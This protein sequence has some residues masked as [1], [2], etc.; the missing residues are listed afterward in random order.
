MIFEDAV[1]K[2]QCAGSLFNGIEKR[3]ALTTSITIENAIYIS[4][5]SRSLGRVVHHAPPLIGACVIEELTVPNCRVAGGSGSQV[6][7]SS[8][9]IHTVIA[10]NAVFHRHVGA[11]ANVVNTPTSNRKTSA[12]P[13]NGETIEQSGRRDVVE[14]NHVIANPV[15]TQRSDVGGHVAVTERILAPGKAAIH[16]HARRDGEAGCRKATRNINPRSH[17]NLIA[18]GGC[19]E[20]RL[21]AR[22][23]IGPGTAIIC[24]GGEGAIDSANNGKGGEGDEK[25]EKKEGNGTFHE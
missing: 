24:S 22:V 9:L 12:C 2:T 14:R 19:A 16:A 13:G 18:R 11:S 5:A 20:G 10:D 8:A 7:H 21:Q 3:L 4:A 23:S 6:I 25:T 1:R 17:P 15:A